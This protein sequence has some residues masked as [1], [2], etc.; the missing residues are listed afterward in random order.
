MEQSYRKA[1]EE[2]ERMKEKINKLERDL[3]EKGHAKTSEDMDELNSATEGLNKLTDSLILRSGR[4]WEEY[5]R[6]EHE[7]MIRAFEPA[8]LDLWKVLCK[9]SEQLAADLLCY[10][11]A[12]FKRT[13][14]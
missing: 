14:K 13:S 1:L 9:R 3:S 7:C 10:S 11:L 8:G 4:A 5:K 2:I 12:R 6:L